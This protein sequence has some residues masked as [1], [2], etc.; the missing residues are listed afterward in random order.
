MHKMMCL[1]IANLSV[2]PDEIVPENYLRHSLEMYEIGAQN[3]TWILS[4]YT[5]VVLVYMYI[6]AT[7]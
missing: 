6:S 4:L 7:R 5:P 1:F 2:L 3:R